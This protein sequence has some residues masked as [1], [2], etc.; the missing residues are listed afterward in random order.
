MELSGWF[1]LR[2][3][4]LFSVLSCKNIQRFVFIKIEFIHYKQLLIT[5]KYTY[6]FP[7]SSLRWSQWDAGPPLPPCGSLG[8]R[9]GCTY[10]ENSPMATNNNIVLCVPMLER[11]MRLQPSGRGSPHLSH[12]VS[13][14]KVEF[15]GNGGTPIPTNT[16]PFLRQEVYSNVGEDA[17]VPPPP[18]NREK[19]QSTYIFTIHTKLQIYKYKNI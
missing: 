13:L 8:T 14:K 12:P 5:N 17:K 3:C 7:D 15:V 11:S 10:T 6:I 18:T 9:V 2:E 1:A 16:R 19:V 4:V